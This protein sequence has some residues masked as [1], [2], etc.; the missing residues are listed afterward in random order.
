MTIADLT[1]AAPGSNAWVDED[2]ICWRRAASSRRTVPDRT[3]E[4]DHS[5]PPF[6]VGTPDRLD[7]PLAGFASHAVISRTACIECDVVHD[8]YQDNTLAITGFDAGTRQVSYPLALLLEATRR[9]QIGE[10]HQW[11]V[12]EDL[13][14]DAHRSGSLEPPTDTL[15]VRTSSTIVPVAVRR[16]GFVDH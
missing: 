1:P 12:R 4:I 11:P 5:G 2:E 8:P 13:R 14:A 9:A 15:S 16:Y 10:G 6:D 7:D 3:K